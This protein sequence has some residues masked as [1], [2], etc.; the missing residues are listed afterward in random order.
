MASTGDGSSLTPFQKRVYHVVGKI[1]RG[2]VRSY[3]SIAEELGT[4]A[5]AVGTAMGRNLC[6]PSDAVP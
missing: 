4:S 3:G 1:P 5:R 6:G 2:S